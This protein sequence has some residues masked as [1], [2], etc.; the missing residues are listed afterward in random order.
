MKVGL[1]G[2]GQMGSGLA[3]SLVKAGHEVTVYDRT[4]AR[5]EPL[6]AQGAVSADGIA[7][8]CR[9]EA[10][11]TMPSDVAAVQR[12]AFGDG[13]IIESL[14]G[15]SLHISSSTISVAMS[16]QLAAVHADRGQ[17]TRSGGLER[18]RIG[19]PIAVDQGALFAQRLLDPHD[20]YDIAFAGELRGG[21]RTPDRSQTP[22]P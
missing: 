6:L 21:S 20:I 11:F 17:R 13:G 9:C 1:I 3:A 18:D 15:G 8:A 22:Y 5:A 12:V 19:Q 10:V 2:L 4:R 7:D 14:G 16:G